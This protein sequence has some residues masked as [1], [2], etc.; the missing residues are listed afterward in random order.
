MGKIHICETSDLSIKDKKRKFAPS[1]L[2]DVLATING[3][4]PNNAYRLSRRFTLIL[5]RIL[6]MAL[7]AEKH[8]DVN[9]KNMWRWI[10]RIKYT[11]YQ[12][13]TNNHPSH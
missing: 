7:H 3:S 12:F 11:A 8:F 4:D 5:E 10:K 1:E 2:C 9:I 13:K 6:R